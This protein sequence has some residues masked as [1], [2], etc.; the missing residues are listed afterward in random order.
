MTEKIEFDVIVKKVESV[1]R[2]KEDLEMQ[3]SRAL[4]R[5]SDGVKTV[6]ISGPNGMLDGLVPGATVKI[7]ITNPQ[8]KLKE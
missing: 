6:N 3:I 2:H 4:L 7:L 5:D 8:T 1:E